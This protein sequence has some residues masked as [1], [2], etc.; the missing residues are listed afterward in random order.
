MADIWNIISSNY[1]TVGTSLNLNTSKYKPVEKTAFEGTWT[2]QYAKGQKFTFQI[3]D[4]QG[5]RG[6]VRYQCEGVL[7]YQDVL[8]KDG[9]FRI[10]DSRFTLTKNNKAEVK[11]VLTTGQGQ[12]LE[13][14]YAT[15]S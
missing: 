7:K 3:S 10:G 12:S 6:K 13:T 11:T 15:R 4:I 2:G 1:V 5:F 9:S 14:S 8:I